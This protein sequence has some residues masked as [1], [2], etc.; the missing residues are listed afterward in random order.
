MR[1]TVKGSGSV[2]E[3]QIKAIIARHLC[4]L[5]DLDDEDFWIHMTKLLV[6]RFEDILSSKEAHANWNA[7]LDLLFLVRRLCEL[8]AV[9][10]TEVR[11]ALCHH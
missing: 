3:E 8:L 6:Q 1:A 5:V 11:F 10:L 9:T 4:R 7:N 2:S